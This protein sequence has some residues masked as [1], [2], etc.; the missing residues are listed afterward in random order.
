MFPLSDPNNYPRYA[1]EEDIPPN[2]SS[3][4]SRSSSPECAIAASPRSSSPEGDDNKFDKA[5]T[6]LAR[7]LAPG[8]VKKYFGKDF[9]R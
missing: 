9:L 5:L 1:S 4:S 2:I 8:S 3:D 7:V 6:E